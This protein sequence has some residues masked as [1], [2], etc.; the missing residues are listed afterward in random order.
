MVTQILISKLI[1]SYLEAQ[2]SKKEQYKLTM[3]IF[4]GNLMEI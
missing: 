2:E 3:L 4:G 1:I